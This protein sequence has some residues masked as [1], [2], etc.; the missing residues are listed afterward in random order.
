MKKCEGTSLDKWLNP[1]EVS[2]AYVYNRG[3]FR[4]KGDFSNFANYVHSILDFCCCV[5]A[6]VPNIC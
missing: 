4:K 5:G 2:C 3:M 1:K 6:H